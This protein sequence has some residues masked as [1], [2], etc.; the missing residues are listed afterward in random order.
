M[1][2]VDGKLAGI[3]GLADVLKPTSK[4]AV[5][6]LQRMGIKVLMLTGDNAR[7]AKVIAA[8]VGIED[9]IAEVLPE[10][11]AQEIAKLQGM[12]RVVAMVGDGINDAPA[13]VQAEMSA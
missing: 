3:I 6:E 9:F 12:G 13:L 1:I 10:N 5:Q 4:E 11:K 8:Q 2:A 7:T